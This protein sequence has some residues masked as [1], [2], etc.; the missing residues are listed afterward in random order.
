MQVISKISSRDFYVQRHTYHRHINFLWL[1]LFYIFFRLLIYF[2][3]F[4][5]Q[6][7]WVFRV[8]V[9]VNSLSQSFW[10]RTICNPVS[11]QSK[12]EARIWISIVTFITFIFG[13]AQIERFTEFVYCHFS[14]FVAYNN[15]HLDV[16]LHNYCTLSDHALLFL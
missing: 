3:C 16:I 9:P 8:L 6:S 13:V 1:V 10:F 2:C 12:S 14:L 11:L 15:S 4:V 7:V 5:Y